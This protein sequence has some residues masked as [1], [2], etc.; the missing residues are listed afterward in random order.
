MDLLAD[1]FGHTYW[2]ALA[3]VIVAFCV[4]TPLLPKRKPAPVAGAEAPPV[5]M[6]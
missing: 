4:A 3:L 2:W 1:A 5:I 6:G